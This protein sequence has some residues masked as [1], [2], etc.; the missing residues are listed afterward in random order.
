MRILSLNVG[1]PRDVAW[2]GKT[3]RT[4][5]FKEP[6]DGPLRFGR[7]G[8][9]GDRQVDLEV[10]GGSERAVYVYPAEH[11]AWWRDELSV[12][13]LPWGAFGENVT[14]SGVRETDVRIG[15]RLRLGTAEVRVTRPRR[16][17]S[18]LNLRHQ[19]HDLVEMFLQSGRCGFYCA[20]TLEGTAVTGAPVELLESD[21]SAP[22]V[23]E[24]CRAATE[25]KAR[26]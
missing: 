12:P 11:Y 19:R 9:A 1:R 7:L 6:V 18:K 2:N 26:R 15:D 10:H 16:P 21:S 22:T 24:A 3:V 17:C 13:E 25:K 5:I 14:A 4:A 23:A 8:V 20:V